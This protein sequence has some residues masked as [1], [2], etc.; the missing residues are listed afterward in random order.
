MTELLAALCRAASEA[1]HDADL[2]PSVFPPL[3]RDTAYVFIPHEHH[4]CEP[5]GAWPSY[6]QRMKTVALCV[7]NPHTPWFE[8]VC[9]LAPQFP[10]ILAIN[11]SSVEALRGRGVAA[12]HLQLGYSKH[13]DSWRSEARPRPIDVAYLGTADVRRDRLIAR[14]AR[15]WWHRRTAILVPQPAPKPGPQPDYVVDDA[16]YELLRRAKLLVN[17]HREGTNS[18]EWPRVLQA[19]ANGCVVVSE[20]STDHAPLIPGEHLVVAEAASIPHIVESLL[21]DPDRVE[22]IRTRAYEM[23]RAQMSMSAAADAIVQAAGMLVRNGNGHQLADAEPVGSVDMAPEERPESIHRGGSLPSAVHNVATETLE[24]RRLVEQLQE[25]IEGRDPNGQ[26]ELVAETHAFR[27][28]QPRVSVTIT[29]RNYEREVR[30]AL[31]SVDRSEFQDYEVLVLDDASTDGS[32]AAVR[33][34]LHERPWMPAALLR[35]RANRGLGASRNALA[36]AARGELMFVLDADNA[37]YPTA[38]GRL[39]EALDRDPGAAFA[40]PLIAVTRFG[41][42]IDLLSRYAWRP[43]TFRAGNYIDAMA[44]IRLDD[45]IAIGGY[46]EDIRLTGWEDFHFWCACVESSRRGRLV[47]EVLAQYRHTD[48]S[49]LEWTDTDLTRAWSLMRARFP[50]IVGTTPPR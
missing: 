13:W 21:A 20:P 2:E 3:V 22:A 39:V 16:K 44:M 43:D 42:P 46:T 8:S 14:Y 24:M 40:Y 49:M 15:W 19:I 50:S 25:R 28:A 35:H 7:E 29:V 32:L 26:P 31:A 41:E 30:D 1:G 48:H 36:R 33:D 23:I 38:L 17:L 11:R 5:S 10:L 6:E 9:R 34:F 47:P 4:G 27:E 18:F 12:E 45:F 37:F